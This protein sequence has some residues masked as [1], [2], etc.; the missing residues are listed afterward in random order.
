MRRQCGQK[1]DLSVKLLIDS[2]TQA[3]F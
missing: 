1:G 2:I 3:G